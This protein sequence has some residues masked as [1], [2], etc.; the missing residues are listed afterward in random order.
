MRSKLLS[1]LLAVTLASGCG[2]WGERSGTTKGGVYGAGAGAAAGAAIG[3]ILGGGSGAWK[4][5]A[6]GAAVGGLTGGLV[7]TYMDRQAKDMQQVL[8][9]QDRID[10][11]G[12]TLRASLSSDVLFDSGSAKL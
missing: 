12:D 3:G 6:I 1:A 4:G 2:W 7:G 8:D 9:R 5:A 10:R 11:E